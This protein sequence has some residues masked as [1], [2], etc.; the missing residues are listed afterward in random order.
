MH[1][2]LYQLEKNTLRAGVHS[3]QFEVTW[4][5]L[6]N[7]KTQRCTAHKNMFQWILMSTEVIYMA[8]SV[9]WNPV[10]NQPTHKFKGHWSPVLELIL[11]AFL[12]WRVLDTVI[13]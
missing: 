10:G 4:L 13:Y 11:T 6:C 9:I 12:I 5:D 8:A 3:V 7:D 2:T 1:M